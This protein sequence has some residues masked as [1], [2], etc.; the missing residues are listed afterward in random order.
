[1][2]RAIIADDEL[3]IRVAYQSIV[4][5]Q[6]YGFE[7]VGMFEN[8]Q[9]ALDASEE[10]RP[11]FVL[12]DTKMPL[13]NGIE[14]IRQL[15]QRFPDTI[16]V[17][18]S[19]YGDLDY[20]KEGM[21]VGADD[22]LL[23]LDITPEKL[24]KL[25]ESSAE[26]LGKMKRSQVEAISEE[27]Q[28]G[29][30]AFLRSWIKGEF[31]E[32]DTVLDYLKFYKIRLSAEKLICI[33]IHIGADG[34][35]SLS[36]GMDAAV[37]QTVI[38]TLQSAGTWLLIDLHDGELRAVGCCES[39]DLDVYA[40]SIRK[41]ILFALKSVM[42]ISDAEIRWGIAGDVLEVP[43]VFAGW[44]FGNIEETGDI[45]SR[46]SEAVQNVVDECLQLH[47]TE[48]VSQ[49][50]RFS[51]LCLDTPFLPVESVKSSCSYILMSL[52]TAM[53]KD[54]LLEEWMKQGYAGMEAALSGCFTSE[55]LARWAESLCLELKKMRESR[56]PAASMADRAARYMGS[57]FAE[58]LSLDSIAEQCGIS[59]TYLSRIFSQEMGKGVQEYLTDLRIQRA[60]QLLAETHEKIYKIAVQSGYGDPVYFNKVFKKIVGMTPKEYRMQKITIE[61][62]KRQEKTT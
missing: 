54:P 47:Y 32:R 18:L 5:W 42:N 19:A 20:V 22:Y 55:E 14:L 61:S 43:E 25:L 36:R 50:Q 41:S 33:N 12:T 17:I 44:I 1:M 46:I 21:R 4:D 62:K 38:Q 56:G 26:K 2:Y 48:A 16:C 37:G 13:C 51:R 6:A 30:E 24:G 9:A 28:K 23:K 59:P 29:R 3:L 40:E 58:E 57:H 53:K 31:H 11:D 49:L 35:G 8:G 60:K 10:L 52:Q 45:E 7:L 39:G 27:R 15:K 34:T